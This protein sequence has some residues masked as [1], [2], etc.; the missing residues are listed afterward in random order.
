AARDV[1]L[2][3]IE[4]VLVELRH[5]RVDG[6]D[7]ALH[8]RLEL[9]LLDDDRLD[10]QRRLELDL[11]DRVQIRRIAD[12]DVEA[13]AAL[14]IRQHAVLREELVVDEADDVE[15]RLDRVEIEQR[16]A[17]LVRGGDGDLPGVA[18]L[19]RDEMRDEARAFAL[20]NRLQGTED[21]FLGHDAVLNQA[22][23]KSCQLT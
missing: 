1:E 22:S 2:L 19:V 20:A 17:E 7:R 5:R 12:G 11:V 3:E 14:Q 10:A 13:L 8:A 16:D 18:E 6:F 15:V 4:V 9:V 21:V 23:R